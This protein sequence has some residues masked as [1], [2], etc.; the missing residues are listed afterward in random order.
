[1]LCSIC[2]RKFTLID[3]KFKFI[4]SVRINDTT[5]MGKLVYGLGRHSYTQTVVTYTVTTTTENETET[6]V[7]LFVDSDNY[8]HC[9]GKK[10][11]NIQESTIKIHKKDEKMF[12]NI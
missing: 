11:Q 6:E 7:E 4:S 8:T 9:A 1:M 12:R 2:Y 10:S 3:L 5:G